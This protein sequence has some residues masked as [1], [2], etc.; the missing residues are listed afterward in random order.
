MSDSVQIR[1]EPLGTAVQVPRGTPLQDVLFA[2]GVEFPCGGRGRCR[3]CRVRVIQGAPAPTPDERLILGDEALAQGWRLACRSRVER[4]ATVEIGQWE[5]AVLADWSDFE[6]TPSHGLGVAV[7]LGSTTLAAQLLDLATGVVLGVRTA[8][9]PQ[10]SYGSDVMSRVDFALA[11]GGRSKLEGLIRSKVGALVAELLAAAGERAHEVK[12]VAI[13]GNTV[14]HHLFCGVS[15]EPLSHVPFQS[16]H[17]GARSFRPDE[18]GWSLPGQPAVT[19]LPCLGGFVG[20]DILAGALA[21]RMDESEELVALIDL[22]TNGEIVLGNRERMAC[23]STAAGPAF[24]GGR[25]AMG[26]RAE[27]GAISE[28][29]VVEGRLACRVLGGGEPR[30]VCGSGL[31]DAAAA[32]LDLGL[33]ESSG[34]LSGGR[35]ILDLAPPV[36]LRQRDVRELQLAKAAIAAG[37]R[38]LL[39]HLGAAPRDVARLYLAGAFG[40]Y[41]GQASARRI[42]LL[43]FPEALIEP[44]GNTA[45]LGAKICLFSCAGDDGR[46]ARIQAKTEHVSLASHPEF[47]DA[48][49]EEMAFPD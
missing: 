32:G 47:E 40:N 37:A 3:R 43:K 29:S 46:I 25:I 19:F 27:T 8:L 38:I 49:V 13:V 28:V 36:A 22:G 42:G 10:A 2:F 26:M 21:V 14:M 45:L 41:I 15:V 33:I 11:D 12:T 1:L 9:N 5:A 24:E 34:R 31:V 20:S 23:A 44:A 7:D 39:S 48:Y 30:G 17:K 18:L 35:K 16:P 6:L 4:G